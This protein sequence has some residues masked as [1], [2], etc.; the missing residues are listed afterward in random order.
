MKKLTA[1]LLILAMALGLVG[2]GNSL[3]DIEM[4]PGQNAIYIKDD[5]TITYGACET[6]KEKYYN[7]DQLKN[8]IEKEIADFNESTASVADA[9]ELDDFDVKDEVATCTIDFITVYDFLAYMLTYNNLGDENFYIG[10]ISENENAKI[11]GKFK[12][13]NSED[14]TLSRD[15]VKAKFIKKLNK[16]ILIVKGAYQVQVDGDILYV[17]DN[18]TMNED[19]VVTTDAKKNKKSYVV[20]NIEED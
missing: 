17:S 7:E 12:K 4:E 2:C 15:T 3:G 13:V 11:K 10:P 5:G 19:G 18:C 6:F 8:N 9:A 20:Y 1:T 14:N 16:K